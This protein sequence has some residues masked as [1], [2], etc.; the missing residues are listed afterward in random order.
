[1]NKSENL[2]STILASSAH[3]MKNSLGML[4]NALNSILDAL[5]EEHLKKSQSNIGIIQYESSRVSSS[6]MQLLSIYK[7]ENNQLAFNPGYHN[8]YDFV[9]EQ[10]LIHMP[11]I[12]ARG[13]SCEIEIDESIEAVFD[14]SLISMVISNVI[15]NAIRY[16]HSKIKITAEI[17]EYANI[18]IYDNGPGYPAQMIEMAGDYIQGIN[19]STGSTGLGLFFA[20]KVAALH[21]HGEKSGSVS[22]QNG[23][24]LGG[25]IFEIAIP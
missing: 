9:E 12:E 21:V 5:P 3:D 7:I 24:P 17:G 20:Q 18:T 22:L 15:G 1:M 2:F 8:L 16:A 10:V 19:N 13:F 25:G 6:L 14:E 4:L 23:G 11:L